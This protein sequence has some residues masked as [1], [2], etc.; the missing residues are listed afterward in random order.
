MSKLDF[1]GLPLAV[2]LG[3]QQRE[4]VAA[5]DEIER[6]KRPLDVDELTDSLL[7]AAHLADDA[8]RQWRSARAWR[9]S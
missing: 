7:N 9:S 5:R 3:K 4:L 1:Q 8:P 2:M 6:I